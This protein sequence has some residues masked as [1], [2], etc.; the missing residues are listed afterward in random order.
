MGS[1]YCQRICV[2]CKDTS[3]Y[4]IHFLVILKFTRTILPY[5]ICKTNAVLLL[6]TLLFAQTGVADHT[7]IPF[8]IGEKFTSLCFVY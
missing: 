4:K 1:R 5:L 3:M 7:E 2:C 8:H 6:I